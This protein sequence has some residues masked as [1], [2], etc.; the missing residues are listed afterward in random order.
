V[1][2]PD[3][4]V[5]EETPS[6]ARAVISLLESDGLQVAAVRSVQEVGGL[7]GPRSSEHPVLLTASNGH[8]CESARWWIDGELGNRDLIVVGTRDPLLHSQGRLYVITLPLKPAQLIELVRRL[9]RA[10]HSVPE[11]R[12]SVRLSKLEVGPS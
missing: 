8:Y 7:F 9:I 2:P 4:V 10:T 1:S 11:N 6:L 3:V 5:I 12:E